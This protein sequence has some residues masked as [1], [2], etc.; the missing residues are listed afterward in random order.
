MASG[1]DK[2]M[3]VAIV[4]ASSLRGKEVKLV[5]EERN[6]PAS[7]IILLDEPALAGTLTEAGGEPTFI[8]ALDEDSFEKSRFV[9]FAG[10]AN[11][12]E[13][14]WQAAQ[15]SGARVIDLT[16]GVSGKA[17]TTTWIPSLETVLPQRTIAGN[18][19]GKLT[20]YS[21]PSPGVI[22]TCALAAGLSQFSPLRVVAMLFPPVSERDQAG[23]DELENQTT[24][25][26]S[27]RPIEQSAFDAQVAF[28]LLAGYGEECKPALKD[29]RAAIA[30]DAASYL[31]GRGPV[32]AIQMVQ[33][34]VFYGYA[35]AAYAEFGSQQTPGQLESAF[36]NLG[37]KVAAQDESAPSNV[38]V[39]GQGEIQIA[40]V[41]PDPSVANGVWIWGAVDNLRLAAMNAVQ[42]AEGLLE[43]PA[44]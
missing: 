24:N 31:A 39:A 6:F 42:I 15:R 22:I 8:R 37:M 43:Q 36:G 18:G 25:L 41:E 35:F 7:E 33:A 28:N 27:F 20:P 9:F 5:L 30:R 44:S 32:P 17:N 34:P 12:A 11:D 14:N 1:A 10:S 21:S 19:S 3:R 23:V 40:R 13:R 2:S 16:G 38:S 29:L 26:L 4:G